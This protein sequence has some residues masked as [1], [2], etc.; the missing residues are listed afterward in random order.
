MKQ[1]TLVYAFYDNEEMLLRHLA[2]W[3]E[4]SSFVKTLIKIIIV[5]DASP[6]VVASEVVNFF[7]YTGV[8][9]AVYRVQKDIPWN[10]DGARNLAMQEAQ[11]EWVYMTDM[12]H[13]VPSDQVGRMLGFVEY[14]AVTGHY[15]M[16]DQ[17]LTSGESVHRPH[18]NSFLMRVDDFWA[19]G[20]YDEDFAGWYGSDGNFRKCARG[21]GL[22]ELP[23]DA[24]YT[25]VFRSE[26]IFDANTKL[27]RKEG[28]FYAPLNQKLNA[29][30]K[31]PP[32]KAV[33][34]VRF[35]WKREL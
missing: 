21:A 11:T 32:Y 14:C 5:D 22:V 12:D 30:R 13:L 29:K 34:P 25:T 27:S 7:G 10:Q 17:R 19:M 28:S 4:Y 3:H 33:N 31:G 26:D 23:I 15:Y 2:E 18:P 9:I 1:V 35:E 20:G 8:D 24:F 16:P 6:N